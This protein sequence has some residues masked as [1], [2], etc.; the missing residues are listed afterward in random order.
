VLVIAK[1]FSEVMSRI[2]RDERQERHERQERKERNVPSAEHLRA[3]DWP[4][5]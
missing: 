3:R 4:G 2:M 5:A 1:I